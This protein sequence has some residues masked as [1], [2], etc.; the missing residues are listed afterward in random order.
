MRR[1]SKDIKGINWI[2]A[3]TKTLNIIKQHV[4]SWIKYNVI[5]ISHNMF[6][7]NMYIYIYYYILHTYIHIVILYIIYICLYCNHQNQT[8]KV[9]WL[10]VLLLF[11]ENPV[12]HSWQFVKDLQGRPSQHDKFSK[13]A[14]SSEISKLIL[15]Y[16]N[17]FGE[18]KNIDE[19]EHMGPWVKHTV[20]FH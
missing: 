9:E 18:N 8:P 4:V 7:L 2:Q 16:G 20:R 3:N 1:S 11:L 17:I 15:F 6:S 14:R 10:W 19:W 5:G 13:L 12:S